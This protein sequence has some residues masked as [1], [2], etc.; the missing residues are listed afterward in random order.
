VPEAEFKSELAGFVDLLLKDWSIVK[1][2]AL[3][4]DLSY[5]RLVKRP[6]QYSST[7]RVD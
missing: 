7:E 5:L 4:C 2:L 6:S 3:V 1:S